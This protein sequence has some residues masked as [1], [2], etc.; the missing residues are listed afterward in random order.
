MIL[1]HADDLG[2]K[3][4]SG[5]WLKL[6]IVILEDIELF[7]DLLDSIDSDIAGSLEAICDFQGVDTL[8]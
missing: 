8:F 7:L 1:A 6:C 5:A 2:A 4:S 3:S